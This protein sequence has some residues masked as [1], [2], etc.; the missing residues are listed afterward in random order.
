MTNP[1]PPSAQEIADVIGREQ[2]LHLIG[3]LPACGQRTWRVVVYVPKTLSVDHTLV[4]I[5][6][7]HTAIALVKEFGGEILQPSNCLCVYRAY[8]DGVICQMA[9][10]GKPTCQIATSV[11]VTSRT[12][13]GVLSKAGLQRAVGARQESP[14]AARTG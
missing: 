2:T 1:L 10:D 13:R 6:G 8:R 11:G 14:D 3:Q 7:W 5:L 12:V 9:R 4:R